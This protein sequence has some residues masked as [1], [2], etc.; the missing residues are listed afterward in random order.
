[1]NEHRTE[2]A[3]RLLIVDDEARH[4]QALCQTLS[5]IGYH[6]EGTSNPLE[7]M[8]LLR[9]GT[10]DLLLTDM[11]MPHIDGIELLRQALMIDPNLVGILMT[12]HGTVDTAV[13]AMKSGAYD[14]ILKPVNLN[15]VLPVLRRSLA[16][17]RLRLENAT[18]ITQLKQRA[19]ELASSN[20]ALLQ[21]NRELD[22]FAH[23][24]SHDLRT[25]LHAVIGFAE[26][27]MD[28]RTGALNQE[29]RSFLTHVMDGGRRL[30]DLTENLLRF[31]R[32]GRQPLDKQSVD[33]NSIVRDII[34][35]LQAAEPARQIQVQVDTL[36]PALADGPLLRQVF[37]NLLSNAFKY[38]RGVQ[39]P[40]VQVEGAR[41][42]SCS[43]Y[44]VR[45][46]GAGFDMKSAD[47][48]FMPFR[49]LHRDDEF[50]GTGVGLSLVKRIV[51]R[52]G[53][54]ITGK[55]EPGKGAEFI[56]TLPA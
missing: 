7:A 32:L 37:A 53:G 19:L 54:Y 4:V 39:L 56:V 38:T 50:E 12:G 52:H 5:R 35:E 49:R 2:P 13:E 55:G 14:Y 28:E 8:P 34:G 27:M 41:D 48:L 3:A 33:V 10:F 6:V 18:L 11:M 17:R 25:P 26:L 20:Q 36:P 44:H 1:M 15:A 40:T 30:R 42:G 29:Q 9:A 31:S 16:T 22:S 51:E 45:D 21:A 47:Q 23:S 24:I 46:N 43:V